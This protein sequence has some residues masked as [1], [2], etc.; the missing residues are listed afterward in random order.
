MLVTTFVAGLFAVLVFLA[1]QDFRYA[2]LLFLIIEVVSIVYA[3]HT[4]IE[5]WRDLHS[6]VLVR[7]SGPVSVV[8]KADD[9]ADPEVHADGLT[10]SLDRDDAAMNL[11]HESA[12]MAS[13]VVDYTPHMRSCYRIVDASGRVLYSRTSGP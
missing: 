1:V 5:M 4:K 6:K 10:L 2:S 8:I 7:Y 11:V 9:D 3:V 12:T 13:A